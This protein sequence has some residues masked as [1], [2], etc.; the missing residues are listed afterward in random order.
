MCLSHVHLWTILFCFSLMYSIKTFLCFPVIMLL[1]QNIL[2]VF[3][4]TSEDT[5]SPL[6]NM[7]PTVGKWIKLF[8]TFY[9]VSL[10]VYFKCVLSFLPFFC[11]LPH[12]LFQPWKLVNLFWH[13]GSM[14]H[15]KRNKGKYHF[16]SVVWGYKVV[17]SWTEILCMSPEV[18]AQ[19]LAK[20]LILM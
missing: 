1:L 19:S 9:S 20:N 18:L 12:A 11:V 15:I 10:Q 6:Q 3:I 5:S 7:H 8:Y 16:A 4:L 17:R 14:V 2:N 13:F